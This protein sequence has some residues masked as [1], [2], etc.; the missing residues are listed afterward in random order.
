MTTKLLAMAAG[1][2]IAA[3]AV[4]EDKTQ[5]ADADELVGTYTITSGERDGQEIAKDKFKDVTVKISKNAITTYD[6]KQKEVYAATFTL[7]KG[8]T[9]WKITMTATITPGGDKGVGTKAEGL[10]Q[11]DGDTVKLVYALPDGKAPT[12]LKGG[13]KQQMFVLTK[14]AK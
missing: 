11:K 6:A 2:L 5:K 13:E 12:A 14:S 3:H 1:L 7:D 8:Q 4:A 10:I 9:P